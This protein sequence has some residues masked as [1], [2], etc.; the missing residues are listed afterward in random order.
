MVW[1][2]HPRSEGAA[3]VQRRRQLAAG[4]ARLVNHSESCT[5][6]GMAHREGHNINSNVSGGV[7]SVTWSGPAILAGG[8]PRAF[9]VDVNSPPASP[10]VNHSESSTT[11]RGAPNVD[12]VRPWPV[13]VCRPSW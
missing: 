9:S 3:G 10:V 6:G 13:G 12:G 7:A 11:G 2:G 5:P 1:A 8:E 4:V